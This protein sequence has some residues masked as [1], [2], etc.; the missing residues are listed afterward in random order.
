MDVGT[1]NGWKI[2]QVVPSQVLRETIE[3]EYPLEPLQKNYPAETANRFLYRDGEG[4]IG[5]VSSVTLPFCGDCTRLRLSADG[6]LYTCLFAPQGHDLRRILRGGASDAE[7]TN[8]IRSLWGERTDR[9]SEQRTAQTRFPKT[10]VEMYR[11]GG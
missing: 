5:F 11:V 1:R 2:D 9:Y 6:K 8:V 7:L 4:E 3:A 10:K